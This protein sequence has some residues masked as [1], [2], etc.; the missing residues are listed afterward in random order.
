[1]V[2]T[3]DCKMVKENISCKTALLKLKY[4]MFLS[5]KLNTNLQFPLCVHV[6]LHEECFIVTEFQQSSCGKNACDESTDNGLTRKHGGDGP[7]REQLSH[8]Q[9]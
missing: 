9:T 1:M 2:Q 7:G 8:L 6:F 5:S 3:P 4:I